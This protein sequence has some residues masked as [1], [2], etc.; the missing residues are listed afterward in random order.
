MYFKN[1]H[2]IILSITK[3]IIRQDN[4][5]FTSKFLKKLFTENFTSGPNSVII[6][7][8][9]FRKPQVTGLDNFN[10]EEKRKR[11]N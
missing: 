7:Q 8:L 10:E 9:M 3:Y 2:N 1:T 4:C 5:I 11:W 6:L